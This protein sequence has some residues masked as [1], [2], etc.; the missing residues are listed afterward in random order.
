EDMDD[1][2]GRES[3][4]NK[5]LIISSEQSSYGG[6][7]SGL[8]NITVGDPVSINP[9]YRKPLDTVIQAIVMIVNNE[10]TRFTERCG[11]D[12][13]R[14]VIYRFDRIVPDEQRDPL[15]FSNI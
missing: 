2:R 6:D 9:K 8:K 15:L 13:R 14:R 5:N 12:D 4:I 10:A 3:F 11:G 7:G 1:P